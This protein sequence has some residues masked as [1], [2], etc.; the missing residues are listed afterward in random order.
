MKS[1]GFLVLSL[2]GIAGLLT[3]HGAFAGPAVGARSS[4]YRGSSG[5][6]VYAAPVVVSPAPVFVSPADVVVSPA[7][8]VVSPAA[9]LFAANLAPANLSQGGQEEQE[10]TAPATIFATVPAGAQVWLDG[11]KTTQTGAVR[12]FVT[13]P[14]QRGKGFTYDVRVHWVAADGTIIDLTRTVPVQAGRQTNI[15]INGQ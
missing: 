2:V 11:T 13:P 1:S 12:S 10:A 7:A 6:N 15:A 5:T 14:L 4:P 8:V 3:A 9:P